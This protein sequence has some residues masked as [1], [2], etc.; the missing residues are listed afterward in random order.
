M[1]IA[2]RNVRIRKAKGPCREIAKRF[3]LS[4]SYVRM[5]RQF[6]N[7]EEL[8]AWQLQYM[9]AWTKTAKGR[10]NVQK[11]DAIRKI[12][13]PHYFRD[14]IKT[15][16][17]RANAAK[18]RASYRG[19][20]LGAYVHCSRFDSIVVWPRGRTLPCYW[21]GKRR[22]ATIDHLTPLTRGGKHRI[23]NVQI[24][25]FSCNA[26]KNNK[27]PS[28]FVRY[29]RSL[30][31]PVVRDGSAKREWRKGCIIRNSSTCSQE[32]LSTCPIKIANY[33][34]G[35][36]RGRIR[37]GTAYREAPTPIYYS[38]K[39]AARIL[40]VD[41]T[42]IR[43]WFRERDR[44]GVI[45]SKTKHGNHLQISRAAMDVFIAEHARWVDFEKEK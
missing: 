20:K 39:D 42:S 2:Q 45:K 33:V 38:V 43:R 18:Q 27:T 1:T 26:S 12:R 9:K 31:L 6:A 17:G 28:E 19:R 7:D 34:I 21:C 3:G 41:E 44:D 11:Q 15:P 14:W 8:R 30:G 5:M 10:A 25:C 16:K 36:G 4:P 24:A 22:K 40:G 29:R 32:S 23:G 37:D 35:S 13:Y